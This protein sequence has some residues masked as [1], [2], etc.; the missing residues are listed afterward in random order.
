MDLLDEFGYQFFWFR[1]L[2]V[3]CN[4]L[5]LLLAN[6]LPIVSIEHGKYEDEVKFSW[7]LLDDKDESFRRD[8]FAPLSLLCDSSESGEFSES[9]MI[10]RLNVKC[11]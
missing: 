7:L 8:S 6:L 1:G 11:N 2:G 5:L 10:S 9:F 4:G 3:S